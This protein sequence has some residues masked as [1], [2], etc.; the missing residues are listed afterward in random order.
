MDIIRRRH[1]VTSNEQRIAK[2]YPV[3]IPYQISS[4][5]AHSSTCTGLVSPATSLGQGSPSLA[6]ESREDMHSP[7]SVPDTFLRRENKP[8]NSAQPSATTNE[9]LP[10]P[11]P[12]HS[13]VN[14]MQ[15]SVSNSGEYRPQQVPDEDLWENMNFFEDFL[16]SLSSLGSEDVNRPGSRRRL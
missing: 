12:I 7:M 6:R 11:L 13:V 1:T 15:D 10:G 3:L 8:L 14:H 9:R 2:Q 5:A 4:R 16:G